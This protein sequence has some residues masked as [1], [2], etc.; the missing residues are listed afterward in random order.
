MK[1]MQAGG[2]GLSLI[3]IEDAR[4]TKRNPTEMFRTMRTYQG[5]M[6]TLLLT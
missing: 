5:Y 6:K 1:Q 3:E 4:D 2:K